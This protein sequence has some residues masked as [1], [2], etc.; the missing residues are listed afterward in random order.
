MLIT[1]LEYLYFLNSF[2]PIALAWNKSLSVEFGL[3]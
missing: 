1:L 2:S 3:H